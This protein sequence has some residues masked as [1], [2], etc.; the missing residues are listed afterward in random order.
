MSADQFAENH[1]EN[2]GAVAR[3]VRHLA[4]SGILM[5]KWT[6]GCQHRYLHVQLRHNMTVKNPRCVEKECAQKHSGS[7]AFW[8]EVARTSGCLACATPGSDKSHTRECKT[9]QDAWE[10]SRRT[11][12]AEEEKRGVAVD[13][14]TT[15][16]QVQLIQ[17]RKD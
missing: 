14:D 8:S 6:L 1:L 15:R 12:T 16:V 17:T 9:F 4:R 5:W 10:E 7:R 11:A 3:R 13:P 2:S